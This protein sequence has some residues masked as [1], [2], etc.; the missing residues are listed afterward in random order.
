[1]KTK[2]KQYSNMSQAANALNIPLDVMKII[3]TLCPDGFTKSN[4]VRGDIVEDFYKKNKSLIEEKSSYSTDKLE[5]QKLANVVI[6]QELEIEEARKQVVP[7]KD[8]EEFMRNFGIQ[9]G[10]VLKAKITRELPPRITGQSQE[11][12]IE[13][14][15]EYYNEIV[16][17]LKKNITNWNKPDDK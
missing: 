11:K 14:C 6:L 1:M 17:L 15:K 8:V 5:H 10:A 12:V 3:K 13:Y 7:I 9:L 2:T 16:D 4:Q